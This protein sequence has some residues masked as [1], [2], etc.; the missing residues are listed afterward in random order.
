VAAQT[1]RPVLGVPIAVA[2]FQG[3]DS[4]FST[5]QMPP[6]MP[7]ATLAAGDFGAVNAGLLAAQIVAVADS[8]LAARLKRDREAT[9]AKVVE[10][11]AKMRADL[12]LPPSSV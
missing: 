11:N 5:V 9:K 1:T 8:A 3:L 6:G 10:K 12:G 7:V 2:P 4:L